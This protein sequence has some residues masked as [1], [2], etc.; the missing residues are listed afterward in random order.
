MVSV[1]S[2]HEVFFGRYV[3][4]AH[5]SL[6]LQINYLRI[7]RTVDRPK[8]RLTYLPFYANVCTRMF[9]RTSPL[10]QSI[11]YVTCA[12]YIQ[13]SIQLLRLTSHG[14]LR[15]RNLSKFANKGS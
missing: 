9:K 11:T 10:K 1:V 12:R 8:S 14:T 4:D 7:Y 13:L 6:Q 15:F 2:H 5:T 3:D